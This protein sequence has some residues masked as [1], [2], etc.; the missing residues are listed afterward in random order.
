M[1]STKSWTLRMATYFW[2]FRI[3]HKAFTYKLITRWKI[4][5]IVY[6]YIYK[7][8][9]CNLSAPSFFLVFIL[10]HIFFWL[11]LLITYF[12][13]LSDTFSCFKFFIHTYIYMSVCVFHIYIC[14]C[15]YRLHTWGRTHRL[16]FSVWVILLNNIFSTFIHFLMNS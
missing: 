10:Q 2:L 15:M 12:C 1:L 16:F 7:E 6:C 11:Y 13:T 3:R 4:K 14:I 8:V 5:F 9:F